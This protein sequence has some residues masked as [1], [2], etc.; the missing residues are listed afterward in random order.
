MNKVYML[1][2]N[3]ICLNQNICIKYTFEI[4]VRE[5]P[6]DNQKGQSR[7]TGLTGHTRRKKKQKHNT[8]SVGHSYTQTKK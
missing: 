4:N 1:F 7:E 5:Y 6:R 8:I 2:I 3:Q